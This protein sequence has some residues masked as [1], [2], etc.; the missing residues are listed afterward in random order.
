VPAL[1]QIL[2]RANPVK[3]LA[4]QGNCCMQTAVVIAEWMNTRVAIQQDAKVW[5]GN[6]EGVYRGKAYQFSHAWVWIPWN[7]GPGGLFIDAAHRRE[8]RVWGPQ[9]GNGE[10]PREAF[11][12]DALDW[13][14][15]DHKALM[16]RPEFF[17]GLPA[18]DLYNEVVRLAENLKLDFTESELWYDSLR[19][20]DVG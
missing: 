9:V 17:M 13:S 20:E 4:W 6:F 11:P 7:S 1:H 3:F 5:N 8:N 19:P 10:I 14:T 18:S 16:K 12:W 15:V 2:Y